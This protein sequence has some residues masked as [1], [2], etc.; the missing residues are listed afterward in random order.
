MIVQKRI[1][2]VTIWIATLT[3]ALNLDAHAALSFDE[4][5]RANR[6]NSPNDHDRFLSGRTLLRHALSHTT[7]H[8]TKEHEWAFE[9][10]SYGKPSV[11]DHLP[12]LGFSIS[13][14]GNCAVVAISPHGA[15]GVDI[16]ALERS[17]TQVIIWDCLTPLEKSN[18]ERTSE[19]QQWIR[20]LDYWTAKE[21]CAK[22]L[23]LGVAIPFDDIEI[24]LN[25]PPTARV[26]AG[27]N[28]DTKLMLATTTLDVGAMPYRLSVATLTQEHALQD[29]PQ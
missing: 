10:D 29:S 2:R 25:E 28:A 11:A 23:G 8:T 6:Y 27:D 22:A 5:E 21:A 20:F 17:D 18:L 16:E 4:I 14:T 13:H 9:T 12:Q 26:R 7:G 15:V 3:D 19:D 24:T 1:G